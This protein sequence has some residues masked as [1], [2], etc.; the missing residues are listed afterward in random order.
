MAIRTSVGSGLWS[1]VGTWNTGVPVNLDTAII[2][3][4]HTVTFD[5]NQSGW[6][7]G[8]AELEVDGIFQVTTTPGAYYLK[9]ATTASKIWGSGS[10][11]VGTALAHLPENVTFGCSTVCYFDRASELNIEI[12]C[13]KPTY[14]SVRLT[15][16]ANPGDTTLF[17]DTDLTTDIWTNSKSIFIANIDKGKDAELNTISSV[18]TGPNRLVLT[19]GLT[20]A[21]LVGS[22]IILCS[23]NV[24]I[25]KT[26]SS[27][28]FNNGTSGKCII[29]CYL[30][31]ITYDVFGNMSGTDIKFDGV[32]VFATS[33][34]N[35]T[36]E[37]VC[38]VVCSGV[39]MN[40]GGAVGLAA[41]NYR[42][43][44]AE[45]DGALIVGCTCGVGITYGITV[46]NTVIAGCI[47]GLN[48]VQSSNFNNVQII[49][50][51]IGLGN[52]SANTYGTIVK[53]NNLT[54]INNNV[55][56][57]ESSSCVGYN[58]SLSG[59]T[60]VATPIA[61]TNRTT[62]FGTVIYD[63]GGVPGAYKAWYRGGRVVSDPTVPHSPL[64]QTMKHIFDRIDGPTYTDWVIWCPA[65]YKTKILVHMIKDANGMTETPRSQVFY[66]ENDPVYGGTVI[67][68]N[69][70]VDDLNWQV[71]SCSVKPT[72]DRQVTIRTRGTNAANNFWSGV[73]LKAGGG[74]RIVSGPP[75]W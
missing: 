7:N 54:C 18:A 34:Y 6:A 29:D 45:I 63:I 21:K 71:F 25:Y 62:M 40:A 2:S 32:V 24:T 61:R 3:A 60:Q 1:A 9:L 68:E 39:I 31:G 46:K 56:I 42:G 67:Q 47:N 36:Y 38:S 50:C 73:Y 12:Y 13:N 43:H 16:A 4:G 53:A 72:Y 33:N 23:R 65:N 5:V 14:R 30:A 11:L 44:H 57:G 37:N 51:T 28:L 52:S 26:G 10:F 55:D 8:L 64:T 48:G 49:G 66:S 69:I 20:N 22:F 41:G 19:V 70:M 75:T 27:R 35:L 15:Q 59:I 17:I 58:I 74:G